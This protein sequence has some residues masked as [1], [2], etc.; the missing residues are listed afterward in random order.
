MWISV[1]IWCLIQNSKCGVQKKVKPETVQV[2][3]LNV[4]VPML[5]DEGNE[6]YF[7]LRAAAGSG[8]FCFPPGTRVSFG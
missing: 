2:S 7:C 1:I 4:Q 3:D 6:F 8:L 5:D